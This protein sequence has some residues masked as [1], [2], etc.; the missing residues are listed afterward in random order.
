MKEAVPPPHENAQSGK[1]RV[2][3]YNVVGHKC[4][5]KL[6]GDVPISIKVDGKEYYRGDQVIFQR[7][8]LGEDTGFIIKINTAGLK[9][10]DHE[11]ITVIDT[12]GEPQ[13]LRPWELKIN[14]EPG[15]NSPD[16]VIGN[17]HERILDASR[18]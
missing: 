14:V 10:G 2:E 11:V 8:Q 4:E 1:L 5:V 12:K 6:D 15:R 7:V 16:V 18:P 13:A 3:T 17:A 9:R